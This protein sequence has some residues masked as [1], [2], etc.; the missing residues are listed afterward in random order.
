MPPAL[1]SPCRK[2]AGR[3]RQSDLLEQSAAAV[4]A[5][6]FPEKLDLSWRRK[7]L[8]REDF[9]PSNWGASGESAGGL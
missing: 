9:P 1:P 8:I 3:V 5:A 7:Q 4:I 6:Y 2:I